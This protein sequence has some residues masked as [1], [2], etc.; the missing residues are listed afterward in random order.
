MSIE[1]TK[2]HY[3]SSQSKELHSAICEAAFVEN[4]GEFNAALDV[5]KRFLADDAQRN[6]PDFIFEIP[7]NS[8]VEGKTGNHSSHLLDAL[9]LPYRKSGE[10]DFSKT[11]SRLILTLVT[12]FINGRIKEGKL[13][14][15]DYAELLC[16]PNDAGFTPIFDAA[17]HG[18]LEGLEFLCA[19]LKKLSP[20]KYKEAL[21]HKNKSGFNILHEA[22]IGGNLE[23]LKFVCGELNSTLEPPDYLEMLKDKNNSNQNIFHMLSSTSLA[24]KELNPFIT[25]QIIGEFYSLFPEG[26]KKVAT[27]IIN[28]LLA[29]KNDMRFEPIIFLKDG[30]ACRKPEWLKRLLDL[31]FRDG[32]GEPQI[33]DKEGKPYTAK[34]KKVD[35]KFI[36]I[37]EEAFDKKGRPFSDSYKPPTP[38]NPNT[39]LTR[40]DRR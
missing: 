38:S 13:K 39:P 10:G 35:G 16:E 32:N 24:S 4:S 19:E 29:E 5:L 6:S 34:L 40:F 28:E 2:S 18:N 25:N 9:N 11:K 14:K 22:V 23:V 26:D 33:F 30:R 21:T 1:Q 20:E 8:E 31:G 3:R 27:E 15:D 17:K 37:K 7:G 36:A 12:S